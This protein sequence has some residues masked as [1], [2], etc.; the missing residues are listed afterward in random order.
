MASVKLIIELNFSYG[1]I[2]WI[3][4]TCR[5]IQSQAEFPLDEYLVA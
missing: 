2:L 4:L 1:E 5:S 3:C